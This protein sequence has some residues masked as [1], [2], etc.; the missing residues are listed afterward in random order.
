MLMNIMKITKLIAILMVF[1]FVQ[2]V[3]AEDSLTK[4]RAEFME[5]GQRLCD[6]EWRR[7][8]VLNQEMYGYCMGIKQESYKKIKH[9]KPLADTSYARSSYPYCLEKWTERG[10]S[11]TR[12]IA[13]CLKNE[14]EAVKD[15]RYY[16]KEY[17]SD[18]VQRLTVQAIERTGS[19]ESAAY[20]VRKHFE[21]R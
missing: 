20:E 11:D 13:Y 21:P 2:P 8:G 6:Q 15:V 3:Q 16:Y 17:D 7:R 19:W 9:L 10:L 1:M 18:T 12:M 4:S 5:D 14:I